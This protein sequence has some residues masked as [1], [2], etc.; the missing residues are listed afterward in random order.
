MMMNEEID[1]LVKEVVVPAMFF[2]GTL[3]G[4]FLLWFLV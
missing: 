4:W 1:G 3:G 2:L